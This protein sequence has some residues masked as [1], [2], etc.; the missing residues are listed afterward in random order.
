MLV[1]LSTS[2]SSLES[3]KVVLALSKEDTGDTPLLRRCRF[4]NIV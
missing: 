2:V 3:L 4:L 1:L